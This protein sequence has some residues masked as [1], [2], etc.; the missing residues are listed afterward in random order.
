MPDTLMP[1]KDDRLRISSLGEY[2]ED[3]LAVDSRINDRTP[4]QQGSSLLCAKLQER[5]QRIKDRVGYLAWK[6]GLS[7]DEMWKQL[8]Q[9]NYSKITPEEAVFL[10]EE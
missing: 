3:L 10:R 1:A 5:E 7:F 2:Y 6:R 8:V 9:D 4:A